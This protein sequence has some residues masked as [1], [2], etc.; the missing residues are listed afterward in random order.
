MLSSQI[1]L[2]LVCT[3]LSTSLAHADRRSRV[4]SQPA[5]PRSTTNL[6]DNSTSSPQV[7]NAPQVQDA[8][9]SATEALTDRIETNELTELPELDVPTVEECEADN[10]G[11]EIVT[12]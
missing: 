6:T 1:K 5:A 7:V 3:L 11:Y 10:I 2:L 12:G 4:G 9:A 8:P